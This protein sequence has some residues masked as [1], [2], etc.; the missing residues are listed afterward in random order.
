VE[1]VEGQWK[2]EEIELVHISAQLRELRRDLNRL[3]ALAER[4][5]TGV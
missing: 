2:D 3:L 5:R 1:A 4:E